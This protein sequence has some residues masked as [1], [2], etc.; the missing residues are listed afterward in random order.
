MKSIKINKAYVSFSRDQTNDVRNSF[1][2]KA[3]T[4]II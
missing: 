4:V 3:I 2:V 1:A